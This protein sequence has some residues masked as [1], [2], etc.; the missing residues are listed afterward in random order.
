MD[1][2]LSIIGAGPA[3]LTAALQL[4][5]CG[6]KPLIFEEADICGLLDNAG[7]IENY[8]GFPGGI[9][10]TD[11]RALFQRQ[12]KAYEPDL[13]RA[14]VRKLRFHREQ[15]L[16]LIETDG[17]HYRSRQ[18][19]IASGTRPKK[20][21]EIENWPKE[22]TKYVLYE[23]RTL[24]P[25]KNKNIIIVG[26]GDIAADYAL[27]LSRGNQVILLCRG[28]RL[29]ALPLLRRR[30][31]MRPDIRI[32]YGMRFESIA[33]GSERPM[34]IDIAYA[35]G[36]ARLETDYLVGAIGREPNKEFY[37]PELREQEALLV[38]DEKLILIGDVHNGSFRQI[39]IAAGDGLRAAM[40]LAEIDKDNRDESHC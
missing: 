30:I 5:R 6:I 29:K 13:I 36:F 31:G 25:V 15:E 37:T 40:R 19:V 33:P 23:I 34:A 8:P 27:H 4:M 2:D 10:G 14:R 1:R 35:G 28:S 9:K 39:A 3:G 17:R 18:L 11:L 12:F 38:R 20:I 7:W 24:W 26:G 32:F 16:F 21:P 22:F